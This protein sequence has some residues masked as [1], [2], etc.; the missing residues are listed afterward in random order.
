MFHPL[1]PPQTLPVYTH[2]SVWCSDSVTVYFCNRRRQ[3]PYREENNS[4]CQKT[5]LYRDKTGFFSCRTSQY[6]TALSVNIPAQPL[7]TGPHSVKESE[8]AFF[9]VLHSLF[10]TLL[11]S[12]IAHKVF[13]RRFK[14]FLKY[15]RI[16]PR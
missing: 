16:I 15:K 4:S 5:D 7:F 14:Q 8:T 6:P 10:Y 9:T 1:S 3:V 13:F 2:P 12:V 11:L